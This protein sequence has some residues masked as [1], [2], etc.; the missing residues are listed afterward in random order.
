MLNAIESFVERFN[1]NVEEGARVG[2]EITPLNYHSGQR[3]LKKSLLESN[4][5]AVIIMH[6]FF[7]E[8]DDPKDTDEE[9]FKYGNYTK[10]LARTAQIC[11]NSGIPLIFFENRNQVAQ[12]SDTLSRM[13][14]QKGHVYVVPTFNGDPKPLHTGIDKFSRELRKMGLQKTVVLG[15]YLE[16]KDLELNGC[17][18]YAKEVLAK[19][20]IDARLGVATYPRRGAFGDERDDPGPTTLEDILYGLGDWK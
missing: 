1:K 8:N 9:R 20:G 13:S 15:S 19:V 12:L 5:A 11:V 7:P 2:L 4:G 3:Q 16:I 6:P 18:G 17:V 14:V 10:R